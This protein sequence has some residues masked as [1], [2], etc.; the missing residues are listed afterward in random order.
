MKLNRFMCSYDRDP[1]TGKITWY[2]DLRG[3]FD[4]STDEQN[5]S[6][7][8]QNAEH[9]GFSKGTADTGEELA[10]LLGMS[11]WVEIDDYG[12]KIATDWAETYK[13]LQK[14]FAEI[15]YELQYKNQTIGDQMVVMN[16]QLQ[17]M[18]KI[19][20][21]YDQYPRIAWLTFGGNSPEQGKKIWE[22]RVEELRRAIARMR[23]R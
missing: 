17:A 15:M 14:E 13:R 9:S 2:D 18:R 7:N 4:L 3:E 21:Y 22:Q 23:G 19:V 5:L 20:R 8:S 10:K 6:F 11:R 1:E 16:T 12:R